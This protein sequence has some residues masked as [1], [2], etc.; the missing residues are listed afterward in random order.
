MQKLRFNVYEDKN[1]RVA[2]RDRYLPR[3]EEI[4]PGLPSFR[5]A[6]RDI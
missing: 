5:L 6:H 2:V 1:S 3:L 4:P